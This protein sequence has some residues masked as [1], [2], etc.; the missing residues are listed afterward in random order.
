MDWYFAPGEYVRDPI[1]PD[2]IMP[3]IA[4]QQLPVVEFQ[5]V[6][7][8]PVELQVAPLLDLTTAAENA[9]PKV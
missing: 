8:P 5:E 1:M 2:T 4:N 3:D 7:I 6:H 9:G